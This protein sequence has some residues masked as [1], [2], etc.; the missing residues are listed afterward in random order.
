M[1]YFKSFIR[2]CAGKSLSFLHCNK[3]DTISVYTELS[4]GFF[5]KGKVLPWLNTCYHWS[6]C[7]EIGFLT[8][9]FMYRICKFSLIILRMFL[10]LGWYV[11]TKGTLLL[12]L[13]YPRNLT[14]PISFFTTPLGQSL[15]IKPRSHFHSVFFKILGL[16]T[17][18]TNPQT[19]T[20]YYRSLSVLQVWRSIIKVL[21]SVRWFNM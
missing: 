4:R 14:L 5:V 11:I 16:G 3:F 21:M 2:G 7:K 6:W 12:L 17:Y 13:V 1:I 15:R 18:P 9:S 19:L 10:R 8:S 20:K